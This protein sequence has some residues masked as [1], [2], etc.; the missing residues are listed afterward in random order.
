MFKDKNTYLLFDRDI[1]Q[2]T[3]GCDII[4]IFYDYLRELY[5]VKGFVIEEAAGGIYA[6]RFIFDEEYPG[7]YYYLME[8]GHC[9]LYE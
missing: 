7:G 8:D 2:S 4:I 6:Y 5:D 1:T 9:M 3:D